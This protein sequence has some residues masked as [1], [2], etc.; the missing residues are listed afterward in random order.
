MSATLVSILQKLRPDWSFA[1][2]ERA[3]DIATESSGDWNNSGTGH[4]GL[5]ELNYTPQN[6]DGSIQ[7]TK[8]LT[9][10]GQFYESM[11]Y[12]GTPCQYWCHARP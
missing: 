8:A 1:M 11:L 10:N 2:Y 6:Q 7:T 4:G 9:V 5:C 3:D 12:L